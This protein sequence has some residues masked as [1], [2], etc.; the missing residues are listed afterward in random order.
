MNHKVAISRKSFI[1]ILVIAFVVGI[2]LPS[3]LTAQQ[4]PPR[5]KIVKYPKHN[6]QKIKADPIQTLFSQALSFIPSS[7]LH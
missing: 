3:F 4:M 7:R 5:H 1:G 6:K 2:T